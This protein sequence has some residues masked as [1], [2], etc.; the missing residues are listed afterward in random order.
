MASTGAS[1]LVKP[2]EIRYPEAQ[3]VTNARPLAAS[4][5]RQA[6][7]RA[8]VTPRRVGDERRNDFPGRAGIEERGT[9]T[10]YVAAKIAS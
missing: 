2:A 5:F 7:S 8:R 9:G 3:S 1:T 10:F 6:I 4:G